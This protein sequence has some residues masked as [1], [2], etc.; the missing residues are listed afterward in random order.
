MISS[1]SGGEV[2]PLDLSD[3]NSLPTTAFLL[4]W[5]FERLIGTLAD[6]DCAQRPR[7]SDAVCYT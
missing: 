4:R 2:S 5:Y 3:S 6:E 1:S 7:E